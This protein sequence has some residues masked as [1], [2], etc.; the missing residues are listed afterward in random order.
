[1]L[2]SKIADFYIGIKNST[3]NTTA[4]DFA[5]IPICINHLSSD[6]VEHL[7]AE[8]EDESKKDWDFY[9]TSWDFKRSPLV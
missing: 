8:C 1:M 5:G 2:N 7:V 3:L 6:A 9:E 4:D